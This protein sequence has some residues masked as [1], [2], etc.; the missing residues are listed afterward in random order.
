MPTFT[1]TADFPVS[2]TT[3]LLTRTVAR[4]N[5]EERL[6]YGLYVLVDTWAVRFSARTGT[7]RDGILAFFE[8]RNGTEPFTWLTPF[9]DTAQFICPTWDTSL[10]SCFLNTVSASFVLVNTAA[11][12]NLVA[13]AAPS[14]AFSYLPDF[15]L[16]QKYDSNA[17]PISFGDGYSQRLTFGTHPEKIEWQL[18]FSQRTNAE[19]DLIRTYLRGAKGQTA[20]SWTPP[21]GSAAKFVC[22]EW[23]TDYL[24]YNNNTVNATF[25]RVFEP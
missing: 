13:P 22:S 2:E 24:S 11:G 14:T 8:A 12:P 25:R 19:R 4:G 23:K 17:K 20:F 3:T 5:A 6:A 10:D 21:Y 9:G 15:G 18:G 1:Y 7:D 16:S